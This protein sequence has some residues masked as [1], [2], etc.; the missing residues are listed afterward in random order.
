[1]GDRLVKVAGQVIDSG[2][3]LTDIRDE[4]RIPGRH[5]LLQGALA[6]SGRLVAA[7]QDRQ[8]GG[9]V[10]ALVRLSGSARITLC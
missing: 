1:M 2:E 4:R 5:R 10:L 8:S 3:A 9:Q 6:L 7:S